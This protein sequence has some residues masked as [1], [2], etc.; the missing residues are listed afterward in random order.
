M[1]SST[2]ATSRYRAIKRSGAIAMRKKKTAGDQRGAGR[3]S[4]LASFESPTED[5]MAAETKRKCAHRRYNYQAREVATSHLQPLRGRRKND[6]GSQYGGHSVYRA[7]VGGSQA[8]NA[9]KLR[10]GISR[11]AI[12]GAIFAFQITTYLSA[13]W[14]CRMSGLRK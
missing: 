10:L 14:R 5:F 7:K 3:S 4:C 12:S 11:I 13:P 2:G 1:E 8:Y 6:Q 9:K